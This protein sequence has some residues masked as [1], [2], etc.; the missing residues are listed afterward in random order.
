MIPGV[1]SV[2]QIASLD[3]LSREALL[4]AWLAVYATAPPARLSGPLMQR[5]I[6]NRIQ[7]K[8]FGEVQPKVRA[9]LSQAI[10]SPRG[11]PARKLRSGARL[12]REWN[13]VVHMVEV[14]DGG[15]IYRERRFRS[16]SSIATEITGA[17]WS[18]PRF[19]GL[20]ARSNT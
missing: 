11:V 20:K 19:F 17:R 18:G 7:A 10:L 16:L 6:A 14:V 5:A 13:G 9:A 1:L 4:G 12:V 15:F 3:T 2:D 8:A